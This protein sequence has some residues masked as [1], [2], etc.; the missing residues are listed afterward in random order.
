[1]NKWP[2]PG[3]IIAFYGNPSGPNASASSQWIKDNI[4]LVKSPWRLVTSWDGMQVKGVSVHQKCGLSLR[5]VFDRIWLDAKQNQKTIEAWGMHL[6]GG[7]FNYRVVRGGSSL[8]MHAYGCAVDFDPA[9]NGLGDSTPNFA[10]VPEVLKAFA[11][12]GWTWGGSW[13]RPDG[14]HWQAAK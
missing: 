11:D 10:N 5:R 6:F 4:V 1:M 14:M 8:S 12:E 9:R 13:A 3:E 7:G 2:K